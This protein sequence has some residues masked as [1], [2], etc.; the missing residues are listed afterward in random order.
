MNSRC[1]T[2]SCPA[3]TSSCPAAMPSCAP[4]RSKAIQVVSGDPSAAV[5]WE[6]WGTSLAWF[7]HALGHD[8]VTRDLVCRLLFSKDEGLGF[9]IVR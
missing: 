1:W 6:G 8:S 3:C 5:V 4:T 2:G 9:N 7:A